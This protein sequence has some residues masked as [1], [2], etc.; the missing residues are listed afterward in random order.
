MY[1]K[2]TLH[3][4]IAIAIQKMYK[5]YKTCTK[6]RPKKTWNVCFLYIQTLYKLYK[7]YTKY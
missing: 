5:M 6:F 7:M 2:A 1:K 4:Y 3:F